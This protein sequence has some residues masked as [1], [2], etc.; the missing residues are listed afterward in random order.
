ML[1]VL[2]APHMYR[3]FFSF[4]KFLE[5]K[6]SDFDKA[7]KELVEAMENSGF[8]ISD[9]KCDGRLGKHFKKR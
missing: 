9:T 3:I 4:L 2:R 5:Q 7:M 1:K 8:G 6:G